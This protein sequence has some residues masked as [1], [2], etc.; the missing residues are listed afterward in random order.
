MIDVLNCD[1]II[2]LGSAMPP[3]PGAPLS[4]HPRR[5]VRVPWLRVEDNL[6]GGQRPHFKAAG[7]GRTPEI[8]GRNGVGPLMDQV[9][10]IVEAACYSAKH[11]KVN[12]NAIRYRFENIERFV[13]RFGFETKIFTRFLVSFRVN[14][15]QK[16]IEKV[17]FEEGRKGK[18]SS[19]QLSL[20]WARKI[21]ASIQ[22]V[23]DHVWSQ[24][25][26]LFNWWK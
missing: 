20:L 12:N 9:W 8:V 5:Q 24:F 2:I 1:V 25:V 3:L 22:K 7:Q 18:M 26:D 19:R 17:I 6:A 21:L 23:I 10:R 11:S 16:W 13:Q 14:L 15:G 4:L